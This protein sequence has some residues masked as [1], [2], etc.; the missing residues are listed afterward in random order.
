MF[1]LLKVVHKIAY[2]Y[3]TNRPKFW[4]AVGFLA[5]T[6]VVLGL[7][8]LTPITG[9]SISTSIQDG[10]NAGNKNEVEIKISK[11]AMQDFSPPYPFSTREF[12][13]NLGKVLSERDGRVRREI[14]EREFQIVIP[15][16]PRDADQARYKERLIFLVLPGRDWYIHMELVEGKQQSVFS[17]SFDSYFCIGIDE[18]REFAQASDWEMVVE[19]K[20]YGHQASLREIYAKRGSKT[21]LNFQ[22]SEPYLQC[23]GQM[24]VVVPK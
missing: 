19:A 23:I 6:N 18:F 4:R 12:L 10:N 24:W 8:L 15:S 17:M 1:C 2:E 7:I 21:R 16:K 3:C 9:F 13:R 22:V 20:L 5:N 11:K 14:V